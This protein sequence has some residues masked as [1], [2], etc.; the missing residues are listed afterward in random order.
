M[1]PGPTPDVPHGPEG[2]N[3]SLLLPDMRASGALRLGETMFSLCGALAICGM[4]VERKGLAALIPPVHA[5]MPILNI[6]PTAAYTGRQR[7]PKSPSS[8]KFGSI[9]KKRA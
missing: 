8:A 6:C 1:A 3:F 4:G 2:R 5:F 9:L 7:Q